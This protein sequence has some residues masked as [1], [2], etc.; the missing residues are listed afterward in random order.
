MIETP[1]GDR[2]V[3][4]PNGLLAYLGNKQ[5]ERSTGLVARTGTRVKILGK[6]ALFPYE[7]PGKEDFQDDWDTLRGV[8]RMA[9][10][11]PVGC[12]CGHAAIHAVLTCP[13]HDVRFGFR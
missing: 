13:V 2:Y 5:L 3:V 1:N 11:L 12:S 9:L 10:P 6:V 7:A 4:L 8:E